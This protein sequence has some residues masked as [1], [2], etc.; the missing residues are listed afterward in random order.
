[1][2]TVMDP[3]GVLGGVTTAPHHAS[4][5]QEFLDCSILSLAS[6]GTQMA[7]DLHL[8]VGAWGNQS[9]LGLDHL[10]GVEVDLDF[11]II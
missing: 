5:P 10:Q 6:A 11:Q 3:V 9:I 2:S 8:V 7:T 4:Y 1:M